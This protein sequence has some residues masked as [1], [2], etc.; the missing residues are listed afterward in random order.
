MKRLLVLLLGL[1]C[2]SSSV[3]AD[4]KGVNPTITSLANLP[5]IASGTVLGNSSGSPAAPSANA[6]FALGGAAPGTGTPIM[7]AVTT[8][9]DFLVTPPNY[10]TIK[11]TTLTPSSATTNIWQNDNSYV[12]LNGSGTH[13]G[14][15]NVTHSVFYTF[16][17]STAAQVENNETQML[18]FG[19]IGA[20]NGQLNIPINE[21]AGTVTSQLVGTK[22]QLTNANSTAGSIAQYIALDLEAMAGGGSLPTNYEFISERDANASSVFLG[23]ITIGTISPQSNKLYVQGPDTS[24]STFPLAV[25]SSTSNL[26]LVGD[27]GQ[28]LIQT[29]PLNANAGAGLS[30]ATVAINNS[31]N[32]TTFIGTGTTTSPVNIGGGSN[33]VTINATT[34]TLG[35]STLVTS[36]SP[37]TLSNAAIR[38]T[39]LGSSSA[40]T[41]GTVCWTT[42]A[43]NLTVD[44]TTTCLASDGRLKKNVDPL[45]VGL[46]EVMKLKP[47]SY[48]LKSDPTHIGR[49]VGLIAQ[50][51]IK[52]DPRLASVYQSGPDEGTPSGVRYEQMVALLVKAIQEQQQEID[53][54][55]REIKRQHH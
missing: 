15:I 24:G 17:G 29:G 2:L 3:L 19:T 49:Q 47:V 39:G 51:V 4:L 37:V 1:C 21:S 25:K 14:E 34:L 36:T 26:L 46:N 11:Q 42:G 20:W 55:K 43:N 10:W 40:S 16:A 54:L 53:Q 9:D 33:A 38:L 32:F 50:D 30:G 45:D 18:N 52:V 6:F 28:V 35:G 48:E 31:S 41:T 13:T 27:D 5:Q 12:Y 22:Y 44:T 23:N 8:T 7:S